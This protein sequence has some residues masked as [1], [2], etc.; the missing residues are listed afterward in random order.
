MK[1]T[2]KRVLITLEVLVTLVWVYM[3]LRW[4]YYPSTLL[5]LGYL[6]ALVWVAVK[7]PKWLPVV[8][9][10]TVPLEVSKEFIPAYSLSERVAGYN[11]SALDFFRLAQAAIC[12]RWL[13]DLWQ[14]RKSLLSNRLKV[15]RRVRGDALLWLPTALFAVY[16]LSTVFSVSLKDS[17]V[18][19]IRLLSLLLTFYF[20]AAY[21]QTEKDLH[22]LSYTLITVG[23]VLGL[24][25]IGEYFS[26]H[27]FF[28]ATGVV[29]INR[30]ANATFADPNILGR[31]LV[32]T[33]LFAV[34]E[35]ERRIHWRDRLIPLLAI[36]LQG[37]GLGITGSRSGILALGV[38]VLIFVVLIPRRKLTLFSI[39]LM[40]FAI[41][42]AALINPV[43][44][45]RFESLRTGLLS[46]AGGIREYLWRASIAMIKDHPLL[47]VGIGT[48]SF[49]FTTMYPYFNP[50]STF[51]VSE[52]HTAALTIL[53]ETGFIGFTVL[54]F[55]FG[56]TIQRGW[57]ISRT[58]SHEF[59]R[60][61]SASLVAGVIAIF[62]SAQ[63]EG[64]LYEE[65]L[66][67]ILWAMLVAISQLSNK[68]SGKE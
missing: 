41:V 61:S 8:L 39:I 57:E 53:A 13:S 35:L 3:V 59:L 54:F 56:K 7:R 14:K 60:F 31:F 16:L 37:V 50:Y 55:L 32:V 26:G 12:F 43:I 33:F 65:P 58:R 62:V 28:S 10:I 5:V 66:L 15:W 24:I 29:V 30:R 38:S 6:W 19:S 64:R 47:G 22:R 40:V 49:S 20:V 34:A 67:W 48:F 23:S 51:A 45:S 11:V 21:V 1:I 63:G 36:L 25:A 42:A 4:I 52:S 2:D 9:I 44:M 27:F 46:A 17:L 68:N 18:E